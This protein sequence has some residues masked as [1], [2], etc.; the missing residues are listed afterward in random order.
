[1]KVE[2]THIPVCFRV[3]SP[4]WQG[5]TFR[6]RFETR[7]GFFQWEEKCSG[8]NSALLAAME[9]KINNPAVKWYAK[10]TIRDVT[11]CVQLQSSNRT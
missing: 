5:R 4:G 11:D 1:M 3:E 6:I 7:Y 8:I 10:P 2:W 9:F